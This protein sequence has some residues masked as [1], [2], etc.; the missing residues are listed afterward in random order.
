MK[1]RARSL[2]RT[3]L[4]GILLPVVALVLANAF[5]L[6]RETLKAVN[7]AY[8]RTLLASAKSIGEQLDVVGFDGDAQLRATVP[9][10]ALDAFE[11]DTKSRLFYRVS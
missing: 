11:A 10:S 5:S 6:Y 3:L 4:A 1:Q 9:Y 7:T 8:D 2:R